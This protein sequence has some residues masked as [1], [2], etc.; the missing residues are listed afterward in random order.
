MLELHYDM[1]TSVSAIGNHE[2]DHG[3]QVL[4]ENFIQSK[5]KIKW[6]CSNIHLKKQ[7][8]SVIRKRY[9][10]NFKD[11]VIHDVVMVEL[12][13]RKIGIFALLD[14]NTKKKMSETNRKDFLQVFEMEEDIKEVS[15]RC[16]K[17]LKEQGADFIIAIANMDGY[18]SE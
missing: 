16:V 13:G 5:N 9:K 14:K 17:K 3:I 11:I 8:A 18:Y 12:K 6:V 2:F 15:E 7:K 1:G 4:L 10:V